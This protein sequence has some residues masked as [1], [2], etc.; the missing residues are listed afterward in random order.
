MVSKS[1]FHFWSILLCG[2]LTYCY[3]VIILN[4]LNKKI[5]RDSI[6]NIATLLFYYTQHLS[7]LLQ[8]Q[9]QDLSYSIL[10]SLTFE[11]FGK[12]ICFS[13]NSIIGSFFNANSSGSFTSQMNYFEQ[14]TDQLTVFNLNYYF[15]QYIHFQVIWVNLML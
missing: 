3:S 2:I 12:F 14:F 4:K 13:L 9:E 5:L 11:T 8:E 1:Q 6:I 10:V 7:I 15:I